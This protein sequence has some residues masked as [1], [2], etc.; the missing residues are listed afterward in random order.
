MGFGDALTTLTI[1]E[2]EMG[3]TGGNDED[4]L[5]GSPVV[6]GVVDN[7]GCGSGES[8]GV[9][10]S[11][12]DGDSLGVDTGAPTV[13]IIGLSRSSANERGVTKKTQITSKPRMYFLA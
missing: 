13:P 5:L 4:E 6:S 1:G 3:S 12:G 10:E 7:A 2:S 9:G 11:V 8:V